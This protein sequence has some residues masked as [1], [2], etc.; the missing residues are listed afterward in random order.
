VQ[1]LPYGAVT[2]GSGGIK[3]RT[4][5]SAGRIAPESRRSTIG[6]SNESRPG[7]PILRAECRGH[8][9]TR[10]PR[11]GPSRT[12]SGHGP[13][14]VDP[15]T[16][17]ATGRSLPGGISPGLG[18]ASRHQQP[19]AKSRTTDVVRTIPE[20]GGRLASPHTVAQGK[21]E[22]LSMRNTESMYRRSLLGILAGF[23][24][25]GFSAAYGSN[26]TSTL[27]KPVKACSLMSKSKAASTFALASGYRPQQLAPTNDQSYCVYPG[28]TSGTYL[29][30]NVT[31]S[32]GEVS[33]LRRHTTATIQWPPGRFP[34]VNPY[35]RRGSRES[36]STGTRRIGVPA[37]R[38]PSMG[39]PTTRRS[40]RRLGTATSYLFPPW[41][42][43]NPR[44]NR[45]C[46]RC[47]EGSDPCPPNTGS[48]SLID[49]DEWHLG[50]IGFRPLRSTVCQDGVRSRGEDK[51]RP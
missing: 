11:S 51:S 43:R 50:E 24:L 1:F 47:Y 13:S 22:S 15:T 45:S 21:R 7:W 19:C 17:A 12:R 38:C 40:W 46:S 27:P 32:Q 39:P 20:P 35:P 6:K 8:P 33:T 3:E 25:I 30:V 36:Q 31:W 5:R 26:T 48:W 42:S 37:S 10:D 14:Q 29:M 41:D 18:F 2:A 44:T 4:N 34:R 49:R 23:G 9:R 28:S 16:K